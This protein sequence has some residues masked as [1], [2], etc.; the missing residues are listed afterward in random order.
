M[1][2]R[3]MQVSKK[4]FLDSIDYCP[5]LP[6]VLTVRCPKLSRSLNGQIYFC[7]NN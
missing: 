4:K 3:D 6:R 1:N 2:D 5:S 7:T